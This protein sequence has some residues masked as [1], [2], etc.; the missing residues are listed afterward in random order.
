MSKQFCGSYVAIVT[1]MTTTGEIDYPALKNLLEW[2]IAEGGDGIVIAGTTG[3]SPTLGVREHQEII[4]RTVEFVAGRVPVIAGVGANSTREAVELT[5]QAQNDG[6]DAGLSVVPYYNKPT[7]E[8]LLRHFSAIAEQSDMPIILYD[9]PGRC[10]TTLANETVGA[11]AQIPT[12]VGIK[13]AVGD[14][15]RVLQLRAVTANK[16]DFV[17]LSGDDG[18]CC[19]YMLAGGDGV[20]SVTAN[21]APKN[22]QRM[23][24]AARQGDNINAHEIN[25]LMEAFHKVQSIESNPIPVKQA[26]VMMEKI[27]GGIRLPL[28]PLSAQYNTIVQEAFRLAQREQ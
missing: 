3:E 14:V 26:L 22:M 6:A 12:I 13:D 16:E 19:D 23:A 2:H 28:T 20:I 9:V 15:E 1:P 8:G 7:Q 4:A 17:L 10:I 11:L 5:Q 18:T 25:T 21:I 24:L 27:A